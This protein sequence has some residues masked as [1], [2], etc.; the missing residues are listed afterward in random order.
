MGKIAF[1][2]PALPSHA[3]VHG[4]LAREL[5]ARGHD[6]SMIGGTGL[7][8]LAEREGVRFESLGTRDP[9]L[10]GAGMLR[11]LWATA[12]ATRAFTRE[13]PRLLAKIRP[14]LVIADQA[15]PGASLAAEAAG[16]ARVTLASA[17]PMDRDLR[18]PPPFV[19][20]PFLE[21]EAG[22]KRNRG[23]WRVADLLM[24]LQARA[25]GQG[26]RAHGLP[27][28]RRMDDW[29]SPDLDLRQMPPG[30]DFPHA[31]GPGACA[32][33]P[34]R[35]GGAGEIDLDTGGRPL[36][37]ASLGTLQKGRQ[38]LLA[39]I[40]AAAE[41]LG[42]CLALA[43]CGALSGA[44]AR[45]LPGS[46][47]VRDFFP[48]RAVLSRAAACVTHGGLNTVLDCVAA[49]VPMLVIPLAFEQPA[50]AARLAHHGL[51]KVLPPRRATRGSIAQGLSAI[52]SDPACRLALTGP[53]D[54]IGRAGG[55][56]RAADLIEARLA[57]GLAA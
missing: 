1:C 12:A 53:A 14:D 48:Q 44:E 49:R 25:L 15:E 7:A 24:T 11:T 4:T 22:A 32:V 41:D 9:D 56:T 17:L 3:S 23:G 5:T 19:D 47:I 10:R 45:A 39:A 16:I 34:L 50:T 55:V 40:A 8:A 36:V 2:L 21:G 18:I 26:C 31:T 43:H 57:K 42:L 28:R 27:V 13:G 37:F 33:G 29:I 38:A 20:W 35:E 51:A 54:E 46:P 6:C 52:L 30:L